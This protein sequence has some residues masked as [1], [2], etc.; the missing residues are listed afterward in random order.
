M[1]LSEVWGKGG[2]GG[3]RLAEEV[4]RLCEMPGSFKPS[5]ELNLSI[6]E[7]I[8]RIATRIYRADDVDI[9]PAA[10]KQLEQL[11]KLG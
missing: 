11:E 2:E 7:K 3:I 4:V 9:L 1:A 6:E 5:Y 10:R 8:R